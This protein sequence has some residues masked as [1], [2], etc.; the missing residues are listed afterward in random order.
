MIWVL[1]IKHHVTSSSPEEQEILVLV[2]PWKVLRFTAGT[3]TIQTINNGMDL[4]NI[5]K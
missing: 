4:I 2:K 5:F 3:S 1:D